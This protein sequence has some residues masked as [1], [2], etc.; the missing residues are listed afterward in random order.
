M[1]EH[2]FKRSGFVVTHR[3][4]VAVRARAHHVL[5]YAQRAFGWSGVPF[6]IT[7]L[8]E[9]WSTEC[10]P[11][12][13]EDSPNL[14]VYEPGEMPHAAAEF[15]PHLNVI[16]VSNDIWDA[17]CDGDGESRSVLAHETGHVCLSHYAAA[18]LYDN[19]IVIPAT[20]SEHQAN[21]FADELLMDCRKIDLSIDG[22][23]ALQRRFLVSRA[24]AARRVR[25]L[26]L[27]RRT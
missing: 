20:D 18:G 26:M 21:W 3:S 25:E 16:K 22:T 4:R 7:E 14:D 8:L 24:M 11:V 2:N 17:A 9:I 13:G 5:D 23:D 6:P 12:A 15:V 27:E 19:S 1:I 10:G